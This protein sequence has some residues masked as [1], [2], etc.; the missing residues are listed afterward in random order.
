LPEHA[1]D[2]LELAKE[3]P[4]VRGCR[5]Q[6]L[7]A[8]REHR[9]RHDDMGTDSRSCGTTPTVFYYDVLQLPNGE[10]HFMKS[11]HGWTHS[12]FAVETLE[13]EIIDRLP[14]FK[15]PH[16]IGSWTIMRM[17]RRTS[18]QR[19]FGARRAPML[20]LVSRRQL[21][22]VLAKMLDESEFFFAVRRAR[23]CRG[24]TWTSLRSLCK[25]PGQSRVKYE[26]AESTTGLFGG[27]EMAGPIWLSRELSAD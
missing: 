3:D 16:A 20:S 23:N 7:R 10:E 22:R 5:Q 1:G 8:L 2:C 15:R 13:P 6:I 25:R 9:P 17:F 26:P 27:I 18:S 14:G 11:V 19:A 12:L 21:T 24:I 4:G